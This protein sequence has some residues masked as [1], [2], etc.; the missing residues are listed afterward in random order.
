MKKIL[1]ILCSVLMTLSSFNV[2]LPVYAF[3][4]VSVEEY[5]ENL[6]ELYQD[7]TNANKTVEESANS[8]VIIK[9]SR[10]PANY[11]NAKLVK[12]TDNIYIFQY[13]DSASACAALEYYQSLSYVEWAELD[14]IVEGQSMSYGNPMVQGD[15]AKEYIVNNNISTEKI[16]VAVLDTGAYF[17]A[18]Y[19]QGRVKDSGVNLSNSGTENSAKADNTHG[20]YISGIIVDN[21]HSNVEIVA[22]KVLNQYK[23]SSNSA[24]AT[25]IDIAVEQGADVINLSS[26]STI[27]SNLVEET[28][29]NAYSKGVIIVCSAGNNSDLVSKY[30][31]ASYDEVFTVGSIDK[32]GNKSFFSNYGEAIDFVA[33]GH[34]IELAN[35]DKTDYGTSFSTPFVTSAVATVLSV[36]S[37]KNFDEVKE[38]LNRTSVKYDDLAY[39]D[40][41]HPIE[42]YDYADTSGNQPSRADLN[43][44]CEDDSLAYGK[45]MPQILSAI[46]LDSQVSEPNFSIE[47]G[48][49]HSDLSLTLSVPEGY[50]IYYTTDESYPSKSNGILYTEPISITESMS[51]RAIAYSESGLRSIPVANEYKMEYYA[52]ESDFEIKPNGN[53]TK[54][55][56]NLKEF[57]VPNTINGITVTGINDYAF[58]NNT[59]IIGMTV[60]E[61][62]ITV[63]CEAFT[64]SSI[65]YFTAP[66]LTEIYESGFENSSLIYIYAPKLKYVEDYGLN[67]IE[68]NTIDFPK[69]EFAGISAFAFNYN[70]KLANIPL[71]NTLSFGAFEEC[72]TLRK[73]S[74]QS[75]ITIGSQVFAYCYWLTVLDFPNLTE[76]I[77]DFSHST[78]A[79]FEQCINLTEIDFPKLIKIDA[80]FGCFKSCYSL[81]N[82]NLENANSISGSTF[83]YCS[84]LENVNLPKA[85][86]I[87]GRAFYNTGIKT[88]SLP[89]AREIGKECFMNSTLEIINAPKLEKIGEYCF[90]GFNEFQGVIIENSALKNFYA[91]KL[92][93]IN[94]FAFAYTSGLTELNLPSVTIIGENAFYES[95]VN[96]LEVP[97]LQVAHSLPIAHNCTIVTSKVFEDCTEDTLG[98]NYIVYGIKGTYAETWA[99]ENS[100]EFI[101]ISKTIISPMSS[102]IRFTRNDDGSYANMF[103]VRTR[104]MI[105]D[106]DFKT[107]I[108][109]TNDEA[110]LIISRAGFVYSRNTTTFSKE[111]AKKV[112]Q[113]EVVSG[114]TDA[115]VN[116]I[117]DADGYY[118]FTCIVTDI[119]IKDVNQSV[120]AY[121]YICI[122]DYWY[123]F[124][125][126]VTA[127]F[128]ELHTKCYPLAAEA[129]GW[130]I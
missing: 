54:Y 98:R 83:S 110:E 27:Q 127:D 41:F 15:E 85:E 116:Y 51:V 114:Y 99:N 117:Q 58:S 57:I 8:R 46:S 108:A 30:Y 49:H 11:G 31:P 3:T 23:Q 124:D 129:Y 97:S 19:L 4:D 103:D 39:H 74:A 61:S 77:S 73:V 52:D 60:P 111:D 82:V 96:Y 40:G 88:I 7:E 16:T 9:S 125:A 36:F 90:A 48:I 6:S 69:L 32:N 106:E 120:T 62:L 100:H 92:T 121:A 89:N 14:G 80:D 118:M 18:S 65:K 81:K 34:S 22:Y 47:S 25:G 10:K 79:P 105:T 75:L 95:T 84:Q 78:Y 113:G 53:I 126:E 123:F 93:T 130:N 5:V 12:G 20:S 13:K 29:R 50:S 56:G 94:E 102:Q 55:K 35:G 87:G 45:G 91:P 24:V 44:Y 101:D 59:Q 1:S 107:Y 63:G 33:P 37:D 21:T 71:L 26:S 112:A 70:L 2:V 43:S 68:V 115:P 128:N 67:G 28:V 119:P 104:A 64:S 66:G 17:N 42:E 86:Y 122:N 109:D 72:R 38:V 76:I